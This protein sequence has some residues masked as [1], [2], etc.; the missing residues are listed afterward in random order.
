MPDRR[1]A[2]AAGARVPHVLFVASAAEDYGSDRML[3]QSVRALVEDHEV[4]VVVPADGPLRPRLV[5]LGATVVVH[6][7][8]AVR[9]RYLVPHRV[10]GLLARNLATLFRLRRLHRRTSI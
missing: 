9:R 5:A 1:T 8:Y 2:A 4:T 7:D 10:P 3:L 6:G